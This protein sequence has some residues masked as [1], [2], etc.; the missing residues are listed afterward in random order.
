MK[1]TMAE[2]IARYLMEHPGSSTWEMAIDLRIA[3]VTARMSDLRDAGYAFEKWK[4]DRG[5]NRY[6]I[7]P[8]L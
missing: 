8:A 2:R 5:V 3:N 7:V 6:R 4:D 1:N